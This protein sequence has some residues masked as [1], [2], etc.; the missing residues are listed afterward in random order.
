MRI[1]SYDR[2]LTRDE[3][4]T[5]FPM[6]L[7]LLSGGQSGQ[8]ITSNQASV[9]LHLFSGEYGAP[10]CRPTTARFMWRS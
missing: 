10:K 5:L 1:M 2:F 7:D 9:S 6:L 4:S 3:C 8:S